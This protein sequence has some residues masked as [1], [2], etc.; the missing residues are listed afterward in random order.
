[1][2]SGSSP[3]LSLCHDL[4]RPLESSSDIIVQ[5]DTSFSA[6]IRINMVVSAFASIAFDEPS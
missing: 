4:A 1:M 5:M 6:G 3:P 2:L